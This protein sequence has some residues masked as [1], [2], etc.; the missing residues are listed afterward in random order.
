MQQQGSLRR[1]IQSLLRRNGLHYKA[2][3]ERKTHWRI[4]HYGWLNR[5]VEGC[6]GSL[7]VNLALLL[8]QLNSLD[9]ILLPT[10]RR[11]RPWQLRPDIESLFKH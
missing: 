5:T 9:E 4:H 6:S 7:Q 1:H 8:R 10:A 2:E 3:T 11:L